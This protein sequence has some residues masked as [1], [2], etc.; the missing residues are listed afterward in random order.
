VEGEEIQIAF[1]SR[2]LLEA[3]NA[4]PS[5]QVVIEFSGNL[6]PALI[7]PMGEEGLEYVIMPV[8]ES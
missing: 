3:L 1:N 4:A 6:S 8:R 2:Y 5:S 7:K